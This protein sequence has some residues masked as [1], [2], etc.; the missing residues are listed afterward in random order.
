[1]LTVAEFIAVIQEQVPDMAAFMRLKGIDL[2]NQSHMEEI[3][4][5]G[6]KVKGYFENKEKA[7]L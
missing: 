2:N 6:D 7:M 3:L 4:K 1:L 5:Q